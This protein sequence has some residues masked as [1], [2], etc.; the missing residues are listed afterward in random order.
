MHLNFPDSAQKKFWRPNF[1]KILTFYLVKRKPL[2][3]TRRVKKSTLPHTQCYVWHQNMKKNFIS[4]LLK[5]F[6]FRAGASKGFWSHFFHFFPRFLHFLPFL[7]P[8]K[9]PS[10]FPYTRCT[11]KICPPPLNTLGDTPGSLGTIAHYNF[12]VDAE[13]VAFHVNIAS[14][15]ASAFKFD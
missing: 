6:F 2:G 10:V 14:F 11:K 8:Q 13:K 15:M 1:L 5:P 4:D 9:A 7:S 3:L 12:L